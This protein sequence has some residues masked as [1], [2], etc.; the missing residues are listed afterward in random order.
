MGLF[1]TITIDHELVPA[2]YR[3]VPFQ[4]KGLYRAMEEYLVKPSGKLYRKDVQTEIRGDGTGPFGFSV[5]TVSEKWLRKTDL[6]STIEIHT[7][8]P[9]RSSLV[10]LEIT[11]RKGV[12]E[13]CQRRYAAR[14]KERQEDL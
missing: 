6:S 12:I 10:V 11:F 13:S 5:H 2:K 4:T 1:D 3:G 7:S 9:K 14:K 8:V